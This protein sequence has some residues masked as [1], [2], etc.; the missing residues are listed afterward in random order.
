MLKWVFG[1]DTGPYR[2]ALQ[3]M[4]KETSAFAGS[5]TS[6]LAGAFAGGALLA[7]ANALIGKFARVKDLADR[8]GES[9]ESIQR[10]GYAAEQAGSDVETMAKGMTAATKNAVAAAQGSEEMAASFEKMGVTASDFANLSLEDKMLA[11]ADGYDKAENKAEA[12]ATITKIVGKAGA[13]MI[14]L[15]A[16]GADA[17]RDSMDSA[18]VA[19]EGTV[20]ILAGL[21]DSIADLKNT[22]AVFFGFVIAGFTGLTA[23]VGLLLGGIY[24]M[25]AGGFDLDEFKKSL[26]AIK[27]TWDDLLFPE[28]ETKVSGSKIED[29]KAK[30]EAAVEAEKERKKVEDERAKLQTDIA[31]LEE[32]SRQRQLTLAEKILDAE[33]RM[34]QI[35]R[36]QIPGR[37]DD[38]ALKSKKKYLEIEKELFDLRKEA[39]SEQ[40]RIDK[41]KL[42]RDTEL[43]NLLEREK[44]IKKDNEFAKMTNAEKIES[45]KDDREKARKQAEA[46]DAYGMD[47][48]AAEKRIEVEEITR[49]IDDIKA[50]EENKR[51]TTPTVMADEIRK[52]GGGGASVLVG[53]QQAGVEGR[54]DKIY[55]VLESIDRKTDTNNNGL[56]PEPF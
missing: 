27:Q 30:A 22:F 1:A 55:Y 9:S 10:V 41:E 45:L 56:G 54:L 2:A 26:G 44:Q 18:A 16:G 20:Q 12:L 37:T 32:E 52:A 31:K 36:E 6:Q 24:D 49:R 3:T 35:S 50:Q 11:L 53:G 21:D 19:G 33:K 25:I 48:E 38:E 34:L 17:L 42:A 47:K 43:S 28:K 8:F 46:S 7:G 23:T 15:L 29:A 13:E 40:D 51:F 39:T 4:R 5:V 14:P